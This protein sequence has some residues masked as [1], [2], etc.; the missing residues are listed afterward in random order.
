M[1]NFSRDDYLAFLRRQTH[2]FSRGASGFRGVFRHHNRWEARF[3]GKANGNMYLGIY[4]TAEKA[5]R[6]YDRAVIMIS[7]PKAKTNFD[8]S[9]YT[10]E[11]RRFLKLD[12]TQQQQQEQ[13]QIVSDQFQYTQNPCMEASL[14]GVMNPDADHDSF[15]DPGFNQLEVPDLPMEESRDLLDV[16]DDADFEL[17]NIDFPSIDFNLDDI[18]D[19]PCPSFGDV[20][21]ASSGFPFETD[22]NFIDFNLD[23]ILDSPCLSPGHG[24]VVGATESL[25]SSNRHDGL[26]SSA[27]CSSSQSCSTTSVSG[28]DS[29]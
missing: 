2:G 19:S 20:L 16:F 24:N 27:S 28:N 1:E 14:M 18:S 17:D 9:N 6:A 25:A 21:D 11:I 26:L 8:I 10:E 15:L 5:A 4:D 3:G 22:C 29:L 7:G 13:H 23:D 12:Q